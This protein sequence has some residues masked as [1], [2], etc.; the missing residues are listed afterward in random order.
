MDPQFDAAASP[1]RPPLPRRPLG[2]GDEW[3]DL[4]DGRRFWG[5]FGAAGLLV[6]SPSGVLLQHRAGFSHFGGTW[7]LPGGARHE[8]ES[9]IDGAIRESVE[10]ASVPAEALKVSFTSVLDLGVWSY[11]TVVARVDSVFRPVIGDA[12]SE[13]LDWVPPA[14]VADLPLHPSFGAAWPSLRPALGARP[15]LVVDAANVVGA[16]PDGWWRD[17]PAAAERLAARLQLLARR[18]LPAADLG[19]PHE[20]W[21]P[22]I[23]LMLEG[24]ARGAAPDAPDVVVE[25][26]H[27]DG[28]SAILDYLGGEPAPDAVLV[29]ADRALAAEAQR[30]GAGILSPSR[31]W[32]LLDEDD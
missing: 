30:R 8:G 1:G 4:P 17:R 7:G 26:A 9:A 5:R 11:T 32:Q 18:G 21:W 2:S 25:R 16:R 19:L 3:V 31:L 29:T 12:E 13:A 10:E 27:A 6:T 15:V 23:R 14:R 24:D 22:Q 20:R 28:D